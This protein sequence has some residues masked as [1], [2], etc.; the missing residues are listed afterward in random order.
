MKLNNEIESKGNV[1]KKLKT[2]HTYIEDHDMGY[3]YSSARRYVKV[4]VT[5]YDECEEEE[6]EKET[7]AEL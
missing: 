2:E 1:R 5:S 7:K 6:E 3:V 4:L